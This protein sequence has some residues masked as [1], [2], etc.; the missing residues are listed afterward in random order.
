MS[1]RGLT[2]AIGRCARE[3][4]RLAGDV[5]LAGWVC[6]AVAILNAICWSA[7]TP[8]FQVADEPSHFAYVKQLAEAHARPSSHTFEFSPEENQI[9]IDLHEEPSAILPP[10]GAISTMAEQ[11]KLKQDLS[12]TAELPRDGSNAAGVATS[13]PPLYYLLEAIPYE[14]GSHGSLLTRLELMRLFSALF[15]GVTALFVFLFVREALPARR[16]AWVAGGLSVAFA[17]LLASVSGAVN[18]DSLLFAVSAMLFWAF[19][20]AFRRGLSYRR[21]AAIGVITAAGLLTKLNFAGFFPGVIL[22]LGV[23][24]IR[25]PRPLSR[26][27]PYRAFALGA[28]IAASP[29]VLVAIVNLTTHRPTFGLISSVATTISDRGSIFSALSYIWQAFLPRLP[30]MRSYDAGVFTTR[31]IWFDGLVGRYGWGETSFPEWVYAF[32]G[33]L[34]VAAVVACARTL[35]LLRTTVRARLAELAVYSVLGLGLL[36]LIGGASYASAETET[37]TEARYLLPLL[38][39]LAAGLGLAIRSAGRRWEPVLG[40]VAVLA[41]FADDI[42]S[43]LLVIAR[44]YG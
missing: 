4:A 15:A 38:A 5:S 11:H 34:G 24:A 37:F 43:Q 40:T 8:P 31:Q 23:L 16:F 22:G 26:S 2:A 33:I 44:F 14:V 27:Y 19:A 9:L 20:R 17:P 18:P 7:I 35:V 13:Q 29:V 10:S 25:A 32:A 3:I 12:S 30:G 42:F 36:I 6:A 41:M 1:E 21:A 28:G 39:L